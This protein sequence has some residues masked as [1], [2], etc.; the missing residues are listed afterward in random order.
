MTVN[1]QVE[2]LDVAP[3]I[4]NGH[5][6]LPLRAIAEA[7]GAKVDWIAETKGITL[8]LGENTVGLQI[9]N[10]SAVVN[11]NV[12][13]IFPPYLQPYGDGTYAAT[14][15]PLRVI[16]EGLGA[17]VTWDATTRV[18]TITLVQQP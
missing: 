13:A 18:V 5:T 10:V 14:M 7:L 3:V 16:A 8:T 1:G 4:H 12:V 6:Y 15:V 2:Q 17:E 9:G 11:G